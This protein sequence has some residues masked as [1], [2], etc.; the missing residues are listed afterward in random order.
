MFTTFNVS[1]ISPFDANLGSR[2]NPF[3][4]RENHVIQSAQSFKDPL[5]VPKGPI[6]RA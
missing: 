3:E 1:D 5:F 4:E 2:K 6:I